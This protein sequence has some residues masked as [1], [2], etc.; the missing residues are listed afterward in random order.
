MNRLWFL[1]SKLFIIFF[2]LYFLFIKEKTFFKDIK[3]FILIILISYVLALSNERR[4]IID[5]FLSLI[6]LNIIFFNKK[7]III[8]AL[9]VAIFFSITIIDKNISPEIYKTMLQFD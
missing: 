4:A 3:Y 8:S 5:L 9:Y 6:L 1:L 7:N 2:G